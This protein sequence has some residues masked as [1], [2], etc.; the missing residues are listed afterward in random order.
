MR[1]PVDENLP[2]NNKKAS[3]IVVLLRRGAE[4]FRLQT[5]ART[6]TVPKYNKKFIE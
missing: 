2:L 4:T 1:A 5:N 3:E 6:N